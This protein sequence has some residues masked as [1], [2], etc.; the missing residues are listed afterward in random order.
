VAILANAP[1]TERAR[2]F[3][4]WVSDGGICRLCTKELEPGAAVP[5]S[6]AVASLKS[7]LAGG[8]VGAEADLDMA[9]SNGEWVRAAALQGMRAVPLDGLKSRVDVVEAIANDRL[10]M[11]QLRATVSV[12]Q[13]FGVLHALVVLRKDAAGKWK[14]LQLTPNLSAAMLRE[15][16]GI[17]GEFARKGN[18][19]KVMGI[20]QASPPEGD[21]RGLRPDLWWDN[22]GGAAVQMVEWQQGDGT[23]WSGTRLFFVP[24]RDPH[25]RTRV[26][27][28]FATSAGMYRWRVWSVGSGGVLLL[29]GWKTLNVVP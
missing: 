29:S 1:H 20:S 12:A 22:A 25:L 19:A 3:A 21:V 2:A 5:A 9:Q 11:V 7:V 24:D 4:V 18:A 27:A 17:V 26:T 8:G 10:A 16:A 6:V 15:A 28:D 14:V 23:S 13:A